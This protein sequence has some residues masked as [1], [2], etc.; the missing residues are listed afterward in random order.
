MRVKDILKISCTF[1]DKD[2]LAD[3]IIT[4]ETLLEDEEKMVEE[5]IDCLNLVNEEISTEV[6]PIVKVEK[7]RTENFKIPFSAFS[8]APV[9]ILAVKDC[10]GRTVRHKVFADYVVALGGEVEVWYS[11]RPEL[12]SADSNVNSTL[13]ER[14]FAY[15][16]AREFYIKKGF[17][18]DAEVWDGRF[19]NSLEMLSN[20]KSSFQMAGRRWQ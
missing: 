16:V 19:K 20:K 2:D 6:L 18:N 8:F 15:G 13:P 17:Y 11:V 9:S 3:K 7:I 5:L 1:L 4:G 10:N 12:L 14:V